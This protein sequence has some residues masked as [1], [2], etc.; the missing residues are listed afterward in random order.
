LIT[1]KKAGATRQTNITAYHYLFVDKPVIRAFPGF[2][3]DLAD[4]FFVLFSRANNRQIVCAGITDGN[5]TFVIR[6]MVLNTAESSPPVRQ[7]H[8]RER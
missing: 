1:N 4:A 3:Q 8:R 2:L 5:V 7:L 6:K